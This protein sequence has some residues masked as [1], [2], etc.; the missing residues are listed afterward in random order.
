M[1]GVIEMDGKG[2]NSGAKASCAACLMG[3]VNKGWY[4]NRTQ[5]EEERNGEQQRN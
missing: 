4:K 1:D 2:D 5:W 3:A